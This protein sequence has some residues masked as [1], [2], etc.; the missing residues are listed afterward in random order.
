MSLVVRPLAMPRAG[1]GALSSVV[2]LNG[3]SMRATITY[4]GLKQGHLVT[5]DMLCG[6]AI[7]DQNL[8]SVLLA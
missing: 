4:N 6:I 1:T 3:L 2:N 8:G 5:L 7:L